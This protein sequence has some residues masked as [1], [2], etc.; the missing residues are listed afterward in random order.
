M[1]LGRPEELQY[2]NDFLISIGY[3]N[4]T[5]FD[6]FMHKSGVDYAVWDYDSCKFSIEYTS[7]GKFRIRMDCVIYTKEFAEMYDSPQGTFVTYSKKSL[8]IP[9]EDAN[10]NGIKNNLMRNIKIV[11]EY[12]I[13]KKKQEIDKDF[14]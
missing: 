8:E 5:S 6:D 3:K 14:Q 4:S 9:F 1:L 13:N 11:K 10:L 12:H 2:L 7:S